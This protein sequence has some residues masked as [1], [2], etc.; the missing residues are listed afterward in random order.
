MSDNV[1][2]LHTELVCKRFEGESWFWP[3]SEFGPY[4]P[5]RHV[6]ENHLCSEITMPFNDG[7]QPYG[8]T[9]FLLDIPNGQPAIQEF[10]YLNEI[11][12]TIHERYKE[13]CTEMES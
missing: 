13:L 3:V 12:E 10:L 4:D 1:R 6:I 11:I 5:L 9:I 8:Y 2:V 7:G